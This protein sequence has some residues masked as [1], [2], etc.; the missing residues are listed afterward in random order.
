MLAGLS[1]S[2]AIVF[3]ALLLLTDLYLGRRVT[4]GVW[5]EKLPFLLMSLVFGALAVAFR[6][7]LGGTPVFS[8]AERIWLALSGLRPAH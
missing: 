6:S 1:K 4:R 7:D 2:A 3:P 5:L 8:L